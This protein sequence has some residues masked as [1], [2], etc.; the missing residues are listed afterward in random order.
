M[1]VK[2]TIVG[3]DWETPLRLGRDKH[4]A[5]QGE[6]STVQEACGAVKTWLDTKMPHLSAHPFW[7]HVMIED[8]KVQIVD[9]G[10]HTVF[11]RLEGWA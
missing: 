5:G 3:E 9:F 8:G 4:V 6:A 1:S 7:R 2:W 10:S 11:A